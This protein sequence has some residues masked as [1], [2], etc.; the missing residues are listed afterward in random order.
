MRRLKSLVIALVVLALSAGVAFAARVMPQA[1][2]GGLERAAEA[3][4]K[5]V[6]VGPPV[7]ES[8]PEG[9]VPTE[10]TEEPDALEEPVAEEEE[11][12]AI[13]GE[14]GDHGAVVSE[15]AQG[16]TPEGWANHGAYVSAV[17]RGLA[18]PGDEAPPEAVENGGRM[19]KPEK[20]QT[21]TGRG[22]G[23][24]RSAAAKPKK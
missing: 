11:A 9:L 2:S 8:E 19:P 20:D 5:T 17:A 1:A 16:E 6:P 13:D 10:A 3:A 24:E 18:E 14:P 12:V 23:A 15:A 22:S 7:D 21:A 4:G